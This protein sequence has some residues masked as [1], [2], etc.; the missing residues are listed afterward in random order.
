MKKR[1]QIEEK[2]KWNLE[3]IYKSEDELMADIEKLKSY[4]EKLANYKGKLKK[5]NNC[6][7]FFE[8]STKVSK[9]IER[10]E[11]YISLKLSEDLEDNKFQ[12]LSSIVSY[13]AKNLSVATS[14]EEPELLSYGEKYINKLLKD[15]R[16]KDYSMSLK[17]F[18]R[19]KDHIRSEEHTV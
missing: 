12:E 7:E 18:L 8:L 2:Y 16:F 3:D 17:N 4:P 14:F 6:L 9:I 10:V 15:E 1:N 11:I 19:N 13:I 5:V